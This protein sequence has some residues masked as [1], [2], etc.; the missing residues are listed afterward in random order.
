MIVFNRHTSCRVELLVEK[1]ARVTVSMCDTH[2]DISVALLVQLPEGKIL[3]ASAE[4][5]RG[6]DPM[7]S[8]TADQMSGLV[9]VILG[10][11]IRKN[12][13]RILSGPTGCMHLADL[14]IE[15]AKALV[16]GDFT[17]NLQNYD[18]FEEFKKVLSQEMDG[19]CYYHTEHAKK[20][21][22]KDRVS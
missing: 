19:M 10:T 2:H 14:V 9:G 18:N 4:F 21:N 5:L 12:A 13:I 8:Q 15:G 22:K 20:G 17:M 1:K 7:C 11:G 16:Q 3:D 6:P